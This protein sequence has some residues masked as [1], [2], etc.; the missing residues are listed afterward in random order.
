MGMLLFGY[1]CCCLGMLLMCFPI[2]RYRLLDVT[3]RIVTASPENFTAGVQL[4]LL[5][6]LL[7]ER[8]CL[9]EEGDILLAMVYAELLSS[10]AASDEGLAFLLEE[11]ILDEVARLAARSEVFGMVRKQLLTVLHHVSRSVSAFS[12]VL[13]SHAAAIREALES[14]DAADVESGMASLAACAR[15][16][17]ASLF[18]ALVG[19]DPALLPAF[20][21]HFTSQNPE[22]ANSFF[23]CLAASVTALARPGPATAAAKDLTAAVARDG[24]GAFSVVATTMRYATGPYPVSR[25][26]ALR[27]ILSLAAHEWGVSLL[28]GQGNFLT[29]ILDRKTETSKDGVDLKY[30]IVSA[31]VKNPAAAVVF[32]AAQVADLKRYVEEGAYYSKGA[33][34]DAP[35]VATMGSD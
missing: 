13:A 8:G 5:A 3:V 20:A 24:G 2:P 30:A 27:F 12:A 33:N 35:V 34:P 15:V 16:S 1:V 28:A 19:S 31:L 17:D 32:S 18:S 11:G 10:L 22:L 6:P 23:V 21:A 29:F 14:S 7:S 9:A 25:F 4:G 26:G